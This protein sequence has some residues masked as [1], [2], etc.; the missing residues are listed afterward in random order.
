MELVDCT[1]DYWEFVRCIRMHPHNQQ[2][3]FTQADITPD[4]QIRFMNQNAKNYKICLKDSIPVGYIGIIKDNEITYCTDPNHQGKGV[5][6][7]MVS[8]FV[9]MHDKLTAYVLPENIGSSKVFEK[10]GF[11]KQIFYIK[12]K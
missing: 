3:F 7:F 1:S 10:L 4:Q 9:K 6:T 11:Q 5:G 2:Y 12:S 8:E